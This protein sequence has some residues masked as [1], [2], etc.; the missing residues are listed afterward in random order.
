M[1]HS[2]ADTRERHIREERYQGN[3]REDGSYRCRRRAEP[4]ARLKDHTFGIL[5][6]SGKCF[7]ADHRGEG[8]WSLDTYVAQE[9]VMR[10]VYKSDEGKADISYDAEFDS[11]V[12]KVKDG[13]YDAVLL[14]NDPRLQTIWDLSLAE[15]DA[16]EDDFLLPRSGRAGYST[17]CAE[18]PESVSKPFPIL[19]PDMR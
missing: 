16:E 15:E 1:A 17:G 10:G 4:R 5:F 14:F 13:K 2:Q 3:I 9:L 11:A 12:S 18:S 19:I 8:L 6:R 7:L